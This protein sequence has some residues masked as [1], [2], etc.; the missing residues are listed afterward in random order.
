MVQSEAIQLKEKYTISEEEL[1][2]TK[3][4]LSKAQIEANSLQDAQREQEATNTRLKEKLSRLEVRIKHNL[5]LS[6]SYHKN[7]KS[8]CLFPQAQLQSNATE[9]SEAEL[10]LHS[11]V[12]GLRSELDE[13][14][15]KASRMTQEHN[16][17]SLH[18][19]TAV[20][21]K[22]TLKH[23][24]SQLE[25]TKRQQER[26]LE[27]LSKDV[28]TLTLCIKDDFPWFVVLLIRKHGLNISLL[29]VLLLSSSVSPSV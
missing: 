22:E 19:E 18:L 6:V 8:L 12:R 1:E 5:P 27:K 16:E 4:H 28:R 17:L 2:T 23:T 10:A 26:A 25:E 3:I 13:A 29:F 7:S 21:D 11:E 14:K 9:S 24:I 20:R 15:R